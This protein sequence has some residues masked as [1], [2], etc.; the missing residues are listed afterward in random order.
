MRL[1]RPPRRGR[2]ASGDGAQHRRVLRIRRPHAVRRHQ[3]THAKQIKLVA[4]RLVDAGRPRI[5]GGAEQ[6]R[7]ERAVA[8]IVFRRI[9]PPRRRHAPHQGAQGCEIRPCDPAGELRASLPGECCA[10][11]VDV[12][13]LRLADRAHVGT[14]VDDGDEEAGALEAADRL[15]HRAPADPQPGGERHLVQPLPGRHLA[16]EDHALDLIGH[17]RSKRARPDDLQRIRV[18]ISH[19]GTVTRERVFCQPVCCQQS[20]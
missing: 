17:E 3:R 2:I 5:P 13:R 20:A 7:V 6:R 18:L 16:R 8:R 4:E 19:R 15:A 1:A 11:A 10:D 14:L 12:D 9:V